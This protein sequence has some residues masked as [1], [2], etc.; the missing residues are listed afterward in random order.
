M[1]Q[2]EKWFEKAGVDPLKFFGDNKMGHKGIIPLNIFVEG[3][4]N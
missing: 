4:R 3:A 1:P 2:V